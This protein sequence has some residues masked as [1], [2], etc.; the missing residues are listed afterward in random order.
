MPDHDF[1]ENPELRNPQMQ[2]LYW[3]SPHKQ[4]TEDFRATVVKVHD[5]D[6]ITLRTSFRDFDFPLR[7]AEIDAKE[8]SEGGEAAKDWLENRLLNAEVDILIDPR[9]R[10]EK[11]GRLLGKVIHRGLDVGVEMMML[12]LAVQ[13]RERN[14]GKIL[15]PIKGIK[16]R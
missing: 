15:N 1:K 7:L 16:W 3:E 13:F 5:G 11:W 4:I 9:N 14:D 2:E 8:M 10:V 6:T 12:G